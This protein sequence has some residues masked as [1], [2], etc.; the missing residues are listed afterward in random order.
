VGYFSVAHPYF[1]F[2]MLF[3]GISE[4]YYLYE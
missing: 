2:N 3:I 1:L 4:I